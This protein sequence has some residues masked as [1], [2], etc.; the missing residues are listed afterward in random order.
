M[1]IGRPNAFPLATARGGDR[2]F[3][4]PVPTV[5]L[6][7][8][9]A[10]WLVVQLPA[11]LCMGL[12]DPHIYD[13]LARRV[14]KGDVLYQDFLETNFPG[15]VWTHMVIRTLFGWSTEALRAVDLALVGTAIVLLLGWLPR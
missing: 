3:R 11:F 7:F 5:V 10:V 9:L 2:P 8:L 1:E 6:G 4:F 14:L 15:I 12:C 13:T